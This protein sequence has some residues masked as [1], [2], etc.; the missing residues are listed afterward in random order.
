M[1]AP[2]HALATRCARSVLAAVALVLFPLAVLAPATQPALPELPRVHVDTTYVPPTGRTIAVAAGGDFQ[3]ALNAAQP[4][5]VITLE[6]GATF[7]GRFT[8]PNK[9]GSGW[10]VV[11]T[12]ASDSSLPPPGMRVDPSYARVMPKLVGTEWSVIRAAPGAHH[13]RFVGVELRPA[14]GVF[15]YNLMDLGLELSRRT[16]RSLLGLVG[17]TPPAPSVDDLPHHIIIDRCYLHGDPRKGTRR[18]VALNGRAMAVVDSYLADFKEVGADS[19][20]ILGWEG[21]GPFKVANNF[22]EGA[23]E[24]VMFGG[25]GDPAIENLV[26]A[27]IEIRGNHFFKPLAWKVDDPAYQ[28]IP[29]TIK[30]LFELK[31]ARRVLVEG[32]LF[33]H[34]W[35]HAQAGFAIMLTVRNQNGGSPWAVIE[36]VTFAN[37]VVRHTG[38]GVYLLGFDDNYPS[39]QMRRVMI[40]NNLFEDVGGARWGGRGRLF[41]LIRGAA[42]VV[43]EHNTAFQTELIIGAD[44]APPHRGFVFQNNIAP[45]N[46]HGVFGSDK[47]TGLPSLLHYFPGFVFAKNVIVG[48]PVPTRYPPDNFSPRSFAAVGFVDQARGNYRLADR[49]PY[50]RAGTDGKDIGV[51]FETLAGALAA[52]ARYPRP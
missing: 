40:K 19:Q 32:N 3:A 41:Q 10:I 14:D 48:N 47:S 36:D 50:R 39:Q 6:A 52:S 27:D 28:G 13:Y 33:E 42:D 24:N 35:A 17:L 7:T 2:H 25:G 37:N 23:G 12:S 15:L 16:T 4:G 34:S 20:A 5:D 1:R 46:E 51:D 31:N 26:P 9:P 30:N 8:L 18:G 22:L 44:G 49:S 21:P 43:I 11:R 45:H 38:S 29:W